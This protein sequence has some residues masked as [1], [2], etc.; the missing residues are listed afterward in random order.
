M[1]RLT[2][3]GAKWNRPAFPSPTKCHLI[4][5]QPAEGLVATCQ[6]FVRG[7]HE[8]E[9]A[10]PLKQSGSVSQSP[11]VQGQKQVAHQQRAA[12]VSITK[13]AGR[14]WTGVTRDMRTAR[15]LDARSALHSRLPRLGMQGEGV[16]SR[17]KPTHLVGGGRVVH[18]PEESSVPEGKRVLRIAFWHLE[19]ELP[20]RVARILQGLRQ[21]DA[22][23]VRIPVRAVCVIG[24]VFSFLPILGVWMLPLGLLLIAY[25]VP[26]LRQPVGRFT[27]WG[28]QK[29]ASFRRWLKQARAPEENRTPD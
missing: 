24:G 15:L 11:S 18:G 12:E 7:R 5:R 6:L 23:S 19:R 9:A 2:Q 25:D 8:K 28:V 29:W 22:R 17:D 10:P 13:N 27:I 1:R 3:A 14:G 16:E 4:R 20:E 26:V 21:P